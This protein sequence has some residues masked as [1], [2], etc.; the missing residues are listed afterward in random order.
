MRFK[1]QITVMLLAPSQVGM[2]WQSLRGTN[3]HRRHS[4]DAGTSPNLPEG[5]KTYCKLCG[6]ANSA[7]FALRIIPSNMLSW[8]VVTELKLRGNSCDSICYE[9]RLGEVGSK[10]AVVSVGTSQSVQQSGAGE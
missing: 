4:I 10:L 3:R 8:G 7:L 5:R 2:L 1:R 6:E 9:C